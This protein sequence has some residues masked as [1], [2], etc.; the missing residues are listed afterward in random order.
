M[1]G[2]ERTN[3]VIAKNSLQG[4]RR[5]EMRRNIYVINVDREKNC[6]S[7][8]DFDETIEDRELWAK[9]EE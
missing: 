1:E 7:C 6:Y 4:Q 9:K 3:T 8:G 2:V 5:E